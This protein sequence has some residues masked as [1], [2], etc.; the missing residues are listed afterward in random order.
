MFPRSKVIE[1][2]QSHR[3]LLSDWLGLLFSAG[4]ILWFSPDPAFPVSFVPFALLSCMLS[5]TRSESARPAHALWISAALRRGT[6]VLVFAG[7]FRALGTPVTGILLTG[8]IWAGLAAMESR[9]ANERLALASEATLFWIGCHAVSRFWLHSFG[10]SSAV[11]AAGLWLILRISTHRLAGRPLI[12]LAATY[13]IFLVGARLAVAGAASIPVSV[14]AAGFAL[15]ALPQLLRAT[16]ATE[17]RAVNAEPLSV[18]TLLLLAWCLFEPIAY[19]VVHGGG[20]ALWYG[21]MAADVIEQVR[22]GVFP[23]FGGQSLYQFNGSLYPIRV[24][25]AFHYLIALVDTLTARSLGAFAVQNLLIVAWGGLAVLT[26]YGSLAW[27]SSRRWLA[28]FG[29][30]LFIACPGVISIAYNNDLYMSWTTVPF[31]PLALAATVRTFDRVTSRTCLVLG[32]S[33]AL[34]WWGHTPIALWTTGI[35]TVAQLARLFLRRADWRID[36]KPLVWG[37]AAFLQIAAFPLAAAIL[38]RSEPDI[39]VSSFQAASPGNIV[40]SLREVFPEVLLPLE[41]GGRTLA[42]FQLGYSLWAVLLTSIILAWRTQ[43][44]AATRLTLAAAVTFCVLLTPWPA[45]AEWLWAAV[46]GFVRNTTGNW[47]MNRLY[48]VLASL[49]VVG[50]AL[51]VR[52]RPALCSG[53][54]RLVGSVAAV[55]LVGWSLIEAHKFSVPSAIQRRAPESARTLLQ[56]ENIQITRFA[57][58]VMSQLP[59]YFSHGVVDPSMEHRFFTEDGTLLWSNL[60][61]ARASNPNQP[62]MDLGRFRPAAL[63]PGVWEIQH[64][65]RLAAGKKYLLTLKV[66]SAEETPAVLQVVGESLFREYELPSSGLTKSFGS[67]PQSERSLPVWTSNQAGE[68]LTLRLIPNSPADGKALENWG[69]E[70]VEFAPDA[71]PAVVASW[72]PYRATVQTTQAGW[73][74]TPRSFQTHWTT[75]LGA[76][77]IRRSPQ[78]LV[79]VRLDPGDTKFDLTYA[80]PFTFPL[81]FWNSTL[82]L[83]AVG[84]FLAAAPLRRLITVALARR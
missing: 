33:L 78:G 42:S 20:D 10:V 38:Y 48:L 25:P 19:P 9:G 58:L 13:A 76:D 21:M 74:E 44:S 2:A 29:S 61:A 45:L 53:R 49:V 84:A 31:V 40:H 3:V 51:V 77:R 55:M 37:A 75:S 17:D 67:G 81:F 28:A 16:A 62:P 64:R 50:A 54:A 24:A 69:A 4:V 72:I 52:T 30:A 18:S 63:Q 34:L 1:F 65:A 80:P 22:A 71:L 8:A 23:V 32:A 60:S 68:P 6:I 83:L 43:S 79:M 12:S 57:Y 26:T 39:D 82:T 27:I 70:L 46:P 7:I 66:P 73:L 41:Q 5:R 59:D 36:V 14:W 11:V 56:P 35:A 15:L 47:V